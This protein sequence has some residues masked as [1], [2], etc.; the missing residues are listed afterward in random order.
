[1]ALRGLSTVAVAASVSAGPPTL[2]RIP[3]SSLC[4]DARIP[5]STI[6]IR[7]VKCKAVGENPQG[8]LSDTVVYKGV[9]GPWT[10]ES[11][12]VQEVLTHLLLIQFQ[13]TNY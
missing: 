12:D 10:V 9:Y 7:S 5:S 3:S 1:M 4:C 13:I 8:S 6:R 2:L 11:S